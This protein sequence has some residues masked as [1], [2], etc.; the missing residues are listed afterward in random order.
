MGGLYL[1]RACL[2]VGLD[3]LQDT[4]KRG[5]ELHNS[6]RW[7]EDDY[8]CGSRAFAPCLS[9]PL[10]SNTYLTLYRWLV[11]TSIKRHTS[12]ILSLLFS[13][14]AAPLFSP[15]RLTI[16]NAHADSLSRRVCKCRKWH[17]IIELLK[18][19]VTPFPSSLTCW[20]RCGNVRKQRG[21]TSRPRSRRLPLSTSS[22]AEM[23]ASSPALQL[24]SREPA[25][26]Q[27]ICATK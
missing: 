4:E 24:D 14:Q 11:I 1:A 10:C 19:A 18:W 20:W 6:R 26:G 23:K 2:D 16:I 7:R 21:Y 13:A 9:Q 5:P 25:K 17:A 27:F 12:S 8:R 22:P 3:V 15:L